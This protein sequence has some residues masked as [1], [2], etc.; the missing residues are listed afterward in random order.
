MNLPVIRT[1]E[2]EEAVDV[3]R[4]D[5]VGP[6]GQIFL[7]REGKEW[8]ISLPGE[9]FKIEQHT[10]I[11]LA[12]AHCLQMSPRNAN[13]AFPNEHCAEIATSIHA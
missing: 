3:L 2:F 10:F 1:L 5:R 11:K 13:Y 6:H 12:E 4:H 7:V 9:Q 8:R